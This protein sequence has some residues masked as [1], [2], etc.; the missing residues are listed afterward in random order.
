MVVYW[1]SGLDA[2]STNRRAIPTPLVDVAAGDRSGRSCA[3]KR[4]SVGFSDRVLYRG[5]EDTDAGSIRD[6]ARHAGCSTRRK[7]G[8]RPRSP[9]PSCGRRHLGAARV[10][11][12]TPCT[13]DRSPCRQKSARRKPSPVSTS[14]VHLVRRYRG[15]SGRWT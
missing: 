7:L 12:Q 14:I 8:V 13:L 1:Q 2:D 4:S 11:T 10:P 6:T 5:R 3:A 9:R 15:A